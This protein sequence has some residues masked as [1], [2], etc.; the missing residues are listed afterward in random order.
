MEA[1]S[2]FTIPV[3]GIKDGVHRFTYTIDWRFFGYFENSPVEQGLFDIQVMFSKNA[4]HWI[5][6]VDIDGKLDTL[7]D[8]CTAPIALP[9]KG[10]HLLIVKFTSD[11]SEGEDP[12]DPDVIYLPRNVHNWNIAEY[13]YEFTLLSIP[14]A[15]VYNCLEETPPPCDEEVLSRLDAEEEPKEGDPAWDILKG[16]QWNN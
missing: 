5:L 13:I 15:N 4:D 12:V 16:T 14:A 3:H 6:N 7:C 2:E 10:N 1:L 11:E 8:R 9:V